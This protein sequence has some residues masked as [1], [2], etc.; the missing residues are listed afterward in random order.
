MS[1]VS[2]SSSNLD[3]NLVEHFT[4][5]KGAL[6]LSS[7][8]ASGLESFKN[9]EIVLSNLSASQV[10]R[11]LGLSST[12]ES[13][14]SGLRFKAQISGKEIE[15]YPNFAGKNPLID[16][17]DPSDI[18]RGVV[19]VSTP[20]GTHN[21]DLIVEKYNLGASGLEYSLTLIPGISMDEQLRHQYLSLLADRLEKE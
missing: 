21:I 4:T 11:L 20:F 14:D 18:S 5:N 13:I 19:K 1:N 16:K 3:A 15:S 7:I 6:E 17:E 12:G 8:L 9:G 10:R 2:D